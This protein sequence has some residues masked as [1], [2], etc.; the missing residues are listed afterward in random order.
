MTKCIVLS[1]IFLNLSL[2]SFSAPIA[3][4]R[5]QGHIWEHIFLLLRCPFLALSATIRNIDV[6]VKWF[7]KMEESKALDPKQIRKVVNITYDERWSELELAIQRLRDC[8]K[9]INYSNDNDLFSRGASVQSNLPNE[10]SSLSDAE[11][12]EDS[13]RTPTP[14]ISEISEL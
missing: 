3:G 9:N 14:N 2:I 11:I 12:L 7:Q 13:L 8:P 1:K 6:V 4:N 5:L 10:D